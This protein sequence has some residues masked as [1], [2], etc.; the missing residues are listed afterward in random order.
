M[1]Y[2]SSELWKRL[3]SFKG[4]DVFQDFYYT[5][6]QMEIKDSVNNTKVSHLLRIPM[7]IFFC[8]H[9]HQ[10]YPE[11]IEKP[12]DI[13]FFSADKERLYVST[14]QILYD[15]GIISDKTPIFIKMDFFPYLIY[16]YKVPDWNMSLREIKSIVH[17]FPL[18]KKNLYS[19]F[20]FLGYP[21][22]N[23]SELAEALYNY[24]QE[25]KKKFDSEKIIEDVINLS[26]KSETRKF[27]QILKSNIALEILL[28]ADGTKTT[29]EISKIL[30]KSVATIST[31]TN[32]LKK[33]N[34]IRLK[35]EKIKRNLKGIKLNFELGLQKE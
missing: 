25:H 27:G 17:N 1:I 28:M 12:I 24:L 22:G 10:L 23:K 4:E 8:K 7:D 15:N 26:S 13:A 30:K 34:L 6:A 21:K 3:I 5:I 31:Y 32:R 11:D 33:M 35:D 2:K 18:E 16:N 14:R 19:L 9:F 20:R 29:T